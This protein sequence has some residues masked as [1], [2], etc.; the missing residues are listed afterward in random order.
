[1]ISI[2]GR[3]PST[4]KKGESTRACISVEMIDAWS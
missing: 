2:L 1:M 4:K 3:Q